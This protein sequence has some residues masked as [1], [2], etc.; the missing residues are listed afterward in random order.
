MFNLQNLKTF[1][2]LP[3]IEMGDVLCYYFDV[4]NNDLCLIGIKAQIIIETDEN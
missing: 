2:N 4:Y 1:C 3:L